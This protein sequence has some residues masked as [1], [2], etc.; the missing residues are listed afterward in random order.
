MHRVKPAAGAVAERTTEAMLIDRLVA[1]FSV[2]E[3][4]TAREMDVVTPDA[5]G[6]FSTRTTKLGAR[7]AELVDQ[8]AE[9]HGREPNPLERDRIRREATLATRPAKSHDGETR[10]QFLDR[11]AAEADSEVTGGLA[12]IA[13]AARAHQVAQADPAARPI[14]EAWS[15]QEVITDALA[16]AQV[17]KAN[18]THAD[19]VRKISDLLP[20]NL[21][22]SQG[23]DIGELLDGLA[24]QAVAQAVGLEPEGPGAGLEPEALRLRNGA[25]AYHGPGAR[26]FT[27]PRPRI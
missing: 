20:V 11:I 4:G 3:E 1:R 23:A 14:T 15:A 24:V 16:A 27:T 22:L 9:R 13:H 18:F 19:V 21:G 2:R 5:G 6:M 25:S 12:G 17:K 8:F 10:E 26:C 7:A